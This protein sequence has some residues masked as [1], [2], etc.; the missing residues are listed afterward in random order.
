MEVAEMPTEKQVSK[1]HLQGCE[2]G[3]GS[4]RFSS[5]VYA[6]VN[7]HLESTANLQYKHVSKLGTY[8]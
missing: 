6:A 3:C 1:V 8:L 4:S 5:P 2:R 7:E